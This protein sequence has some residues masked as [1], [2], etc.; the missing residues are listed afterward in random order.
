MDVRVNSTDKQY[1]EANSKIL[2]D[3]L[4]FIISSTPNIPLDNLNLVFTDKFTEEVESYQI[5]NDI[6]RVGHS[7]GTIAKVCH[8]VDSDDKLNTTAFFDLSTFHP[9]LE[10][11]ATECPYVFHL[12]QHEL[13]HVYDDYLMHGILPESSYF[14]QDSL[15][16]TE[17]LLYDLSHMAW[18]EFQAHKISVGTVDD[19]IKISQSNDIF[20]KVF[21]HSANNVCNIFSEFPD[22][23]EVIKE[24]ILNDAGNCLSIQTYTK[25]ILYYSSQYIGIVLAFGLDEEEHLYK[26]VYNEVSNKFM[27]LEFGTEFE[28]L[29]YIFKELQQTYPK[30]E[31]FYAL[32]PIT[33]WIKRFWYNKVGVIAN[34]GVLFFVI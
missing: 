16:K 22:Q 31:D 32:E 33:K 3:N 4:E 12:I 21:L 23:L 6:T 8:F 34:D 24:E 2:I 26:E 19:I 7:D 11:T 1:S 17:G 5:E 10:F 30:W 15:T 27:E 25:E 20:K 13:G 9:V 28:E 14:E 29:L 18:A